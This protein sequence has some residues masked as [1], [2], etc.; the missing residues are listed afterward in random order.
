M[1]QEI[2]AVQLLGRFLGELFDSIIGREVGGLDF[3]DCG[4]SFFGGENG[5]A[6]G[7]AL[8]EAADGE[9]H[10]CGVEADK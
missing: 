3:D 7:F 2:E 10:F 4:C 6:C 8:L 9:D 5:L 1:D